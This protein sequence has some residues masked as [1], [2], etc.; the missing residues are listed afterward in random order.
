[1]EGIT[2]TKIDSEKVEIFYESIYRQGSSVSHFDAY[3]IKM[4]N[5]YRKNDQTILA[6]DP[7]FPAILALHNALFDIITTAEAVAAFDRMSD[8][9]EWEKLLA[10]WRRTAKNANFLD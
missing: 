4:L 8:K 5:L 9:E 7:L 1:M 6:P 10:D 3:S 2:D